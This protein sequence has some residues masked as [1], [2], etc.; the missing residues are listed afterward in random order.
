MKLNGVQK[1]EGCRLSGVA[2][3]SKNRMRLEGAKSI[4]HGEWYT[5]IL[6]IGLVL[7]ISKRIAN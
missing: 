2:Y 1:S 4:L 3:L 6:N 7:A 5:E